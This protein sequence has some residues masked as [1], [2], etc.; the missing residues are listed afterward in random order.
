VLAENVNLGSMINRLQVAKFKHN[1]CNL[2]GLALQ[3]AKLAL[4][5]LEY[6]SPAVLFPGCIEDAWKIINP[7]K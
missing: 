1:D 7:W 4:D 6:F 5:Q 3:A 2:N